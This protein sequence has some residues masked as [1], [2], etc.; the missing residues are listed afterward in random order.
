MAIWC[1]PTCGYEKDAR[2]K[3]KNC[4]EC[5]KPVAFAK[6]DEVPGAKAA[7][8]ACACGAKAAKPAAPKAAAKKK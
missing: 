6:K 5:D 4:P 1:C 8:C 3:P 7:S 2:C